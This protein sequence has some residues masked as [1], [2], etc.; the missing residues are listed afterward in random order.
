MMDLPNFTGYCLHD[1]GMGRNACVPT[2]R[3]APTHTHMQTHS[4]NLKLK[5]CVG[6]TVFQPQCTPHHTQAHPLSPNLNLNN[7]R[8]EELCSTPQDTPLTSAA[9][10][11]LRQFQLRGSL[12]LPSSLMVLVFN[13][14]TTTLGRLLDLL[15][16]AGVQEP[17]D[18]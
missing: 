18:G 6:R 11:E 16:S 1:S 15:Q 2:A 3:Y 17:Y 4:Q 12:K 9:A 13:Y 8:W 14:M 5:N 7:G 10:Q